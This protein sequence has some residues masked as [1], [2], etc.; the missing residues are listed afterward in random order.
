MGPWDHRILWGYC[1]RLRMVAFTGGYY[2]AVFMGLLGV[3]QGDP[4]SPTI[5]NA[6]VYAVARHWI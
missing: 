5:L 3:N 6:M 1:D 4:L 2:G